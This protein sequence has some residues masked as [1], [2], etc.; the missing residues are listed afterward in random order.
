[1]SRI[2]DFDAGFIYGLVA[3]EGCFTGDRK[4]PVLAIKLHQD[5][6]E[7]LKFI[8]EKLGG[9]IYGPYCHDGRRYFFWRLMGRSL[10]AALPLFAERLPPSRKREQFKRWLEKYQLQKTL[11]TMQEAECGEKIN[12]TATPVA[13]G[14]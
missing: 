7:P 3:G 5:D 6:L 14:S 4:Q 13:G 8:Q 11:E 2:S 1:M 12:W 10:H 9:K